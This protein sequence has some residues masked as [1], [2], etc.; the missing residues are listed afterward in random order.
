M[1]PG[2]EGADFL[3]TD[4]WVSMGEPAGRLGRADRPRCCPTRSTPTLMAAT[5]NP[6]VKFMHC[7]PALHNTDTEIGRQ[8]HDKWGLD[9]PSR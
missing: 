7:L 2:V 6:Q 3:Y 8:L 5:G 9:A 1:L 4:V